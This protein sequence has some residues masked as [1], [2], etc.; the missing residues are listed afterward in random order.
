MSVLDR[1]FEATTSYY[2]NYSLL[3]HRGFG[4]IDC[5]AQFQPL[6]SRERNVMAGFLR[7]LFGYNICC[8]LAGSVI[9]YI[10]GSIKDYSGATLYLAIDS[11]KPIQ[12]A[13]LQ[14]N[15]IPLNGIDLDQGYYLQLLGFRRSVECYYYKLIKGDVVIPLCICGIQ[16]TAIVCE[17]RSNLDFVHF[18]WQHVESLSFKRQAMTIIPHYDNPSESSVLYL[19]HYRIR[20][21]G[22]AVRNNCRK[23]LNKHRDFASEYCLCMLPGGPCNCFMCCRQPPSLMAAAAHTLFNLTLNIINFELTADTTYDE[24]LYAFNSEDVDRFQLLPPHF[25][26]IIVFYFNNIDTPLLWRHF[27]CPGAGPFEC[28]HKQTF[29]DQDHAIQELVRYKT[30]YWCGFCDKPLFFPPKCTFHY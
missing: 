10:A 30:T 15:L 17:P 29:R 26:K 9:N 19:E 7:V 28:S 3:L 2:D 12:R 25:P 5:L 6:P 20:S 27:H 23:C 16:H 4:H 24:Y 13:L 21:D 22:Y 8:F 14:Q 18:I 1:I 11:H